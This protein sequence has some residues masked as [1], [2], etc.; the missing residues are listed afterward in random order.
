MFDFSLEAN[1]SYL[2]DNLEGLL[3]NSPELFARLFSLGH[4]IEKIE[5]LDVSELLRVGLITEDQNH[6]FCPLFIFERDR[7]FLVS[8]KKGTNPLEVFRPW[9]EEVD[10][11][12]QFFLPPKRMAK[13]LDLGGGCG[14]YGIRA[15]SLSKAHVT[16]ADINPRALQ[17]ARFN[18]LL[19]EV[20][21][22]VTTVTS[23]FF[24]KVTG[25]FDFIVAGLPY[26]PSPPNSPSKIYA[27]G[28]TDGTHF[29]SKALAEGSNHLSSGGEMVVCAMVLGDV[30]KNVLETRIIASNPNREPKIAFEFRQLQGHQ[31]VFEEWWIDKV[32]TLSS[33]ERDWMDSLKSKGLTHFHRVQVKMRKLTGENA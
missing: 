20:D 5:N 28:G 19:N 11:C 6:W 30:D 13:V 27:D 33:S 7:I 32:G 16:I 8:E 22:S 12:E 21:S 1:F 9:K 17:F 23:S 31:R 4:T 10:I 18:A 26:R 14:T 2:R 25:H 15:A 29:I 24:D 3:D